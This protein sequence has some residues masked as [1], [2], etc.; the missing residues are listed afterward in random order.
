MVALGDAVDGTDRS[1]TRLTTDHLEALVY[2]TDGTVAPGNRF[3]LVVDVTPKDG[4]HVYAPGDHTYRVIS[5]R[6]DTPDFIRANEV[7]YPESENYHFEPLDERVE[8]Y[9]RPFSLVQEVAIPMNRE[10]AGLAAQ[11]GATLTIEG[12]LEYQACDDAIC[13]TPVDL[14]VSW[15]F[16]WRSLVR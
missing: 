4:M 11:P 7:T 15:T 1:A 5:L 2:A 14:P 8:V 12:A 6:V 13:Y 9:E 3:S 16:N 10:I